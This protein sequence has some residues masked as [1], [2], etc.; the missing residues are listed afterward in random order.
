MEYLMNCGARQGLMDGAGHSTAQQSRAGQGKA[1]QRAE[2]CTAG[3][4][5]MRAGRAGLGTAGWVR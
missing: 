5:E 1:G 3:Q 2:L 4:G